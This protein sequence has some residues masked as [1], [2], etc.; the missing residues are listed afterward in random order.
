METIVNARTCPPNYPQRIFPVMARSITHQK[1]FGIRSV[2]RSL[3]ADDER[4]AL[5]LTKVGEGP[6]KEIWQAASTLRD[7]WQRG[8]TALFGTSSAWRILLGNDIANSMTG[9]NRTKAMHR[10]HWMT[11]FLRSLGAGGTVLLFDEL[12]TIEQLW[13]RR[14]RAS[15]YEVLGRLLAA[16]GTWC[17]FGITQRFQRVVNED[18]RSDMF[19]HAFSAGK[20][21]LSPWRNGEP[22][23][24]APPAIGN[25]EARALARIVEDLYR[26]AYPDTASCTDD[27]QSAVA[28][29]SL[30]AARNPRRLVRSI[31]D[32]CDRARPLVVNTP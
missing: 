9:H 4:A 25:E 32:T 30:N 16:P 20:H 29:W 26:N 21:F 27:C 7:L 17:V 6:Q 5:A 2:V 12:E 10:L 19:T 23:L 15:A 22:E 31:I 1:D 18:A 8:E 3:V 13:N 24:V 11:S 14:S 28:N